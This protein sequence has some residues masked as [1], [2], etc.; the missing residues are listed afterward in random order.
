MTDRAAPNDQGNLPLDGIRILDL[1][2]YIAGPYGCSLLADMGADIIK[3]ESPDGDNLRKYPSTLEGES[4]AFLGVNRG[5]RGLCLDLKQQAGY[6]IFLRLV[7][8]ADVL[9]HNFRPSVP[10][11]L[12]IDFDRL[13]AVNPRLIYCSLTGYGQTG[14]MADKAGYDQVLQ[15]MTGICASQGSREQPE[16]VYGSAV[17]YY[18]A[19]MLAGSVAAALYQRERTGLGQHVTLSLLSSAL[20]MQSA[21]LVMAE[22]EPR[23]INRDMRSGGITGIHP[24]REGHL[25]LSA[26]TPHFWRAL[27]E[28]IGDAELAD[29]P[30]YDTVR[31]RAAAAADI[32]PRIRQ[33][34][35]A[36]SA[37]EW[38]AHFGTAVPCAAVCAVED[39]FDDTQVLHHGYVIEQEHPRVGR[40]KGVA[41]LVHFNGKAPQS[42]PRTAPALGEDTITLLRELGYAPAQIETILADQAAY[43]PSAPQPPD[44]RTPAA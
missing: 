41:R 13:H 9:V 15:A 35:M 26:N 34:L 2:A 31:K 5:K 18:A 6:D 12:K 42:P 7:A 36:R 14:P 4:R 23:D 16:I 10:G 30:R 29:D 40:Y 1:S 22:D 37:R 24:T 3:V 28:R 33:A 19:S 38:E 20:A 39:M 32:V 17:D 43:D 44:T 21:R 8:Q 25:Y 11:R 27:C